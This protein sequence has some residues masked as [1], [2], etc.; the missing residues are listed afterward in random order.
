MVKM[1][2]NFHWNI[3][4]FRDSKKKRLSRQ[5]FIY[6]EVWLHNGY[7]IIEYL[8]KLSCSLTCG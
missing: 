6:T 7:D 8:G 2:I 5:G 3:R 1:F 4:L